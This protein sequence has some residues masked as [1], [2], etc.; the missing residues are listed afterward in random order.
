MVDKHRRWKSEQMRY[1]YAAVI[2][3]LTVWKHVALRKATVSDS[4]LGFWD[5]GI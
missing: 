3:L 1:H 2:I 5:V 4:D